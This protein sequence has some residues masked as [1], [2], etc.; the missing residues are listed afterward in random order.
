MFA[1]KPNQFVLPIT[2]LVISLAILSMMIIRIVSSQV[3]P[4]SIVENAAT[5]GTVPTLTVGDTVEVAEYLKY[6]HQFSGLPS[7]WRIFQASLTYA[8]YPSVTLANQEMA[9]HLKNTHQFSGLPPNWNIYQASLNHADYPSVTL[10][11]RE[12]AEY[13]KHNHQ[14]DG[15]S[16]NW[17]IYQSS[18]NYADYSSNFS[19]AL[20][21]Y[22]ESGTGPY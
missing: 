13:L 10:A 5:V 6:N 15:L 18:L 17:N 21:P 2:L 20:P 8:D 11:N 12:T 16:P 1:E 7:N 19:S 9:E 4:P 3:S 14:S 22:G